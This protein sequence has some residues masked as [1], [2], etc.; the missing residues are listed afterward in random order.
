MNSS[1][2][3]G[4]SVE[5][6]MEGVDTVISAVILGVETIGLW[7]H[8]GNVLEKIDAS[9]SGIR[10]QALKDP[11]VFLPFARI[12]WLISEAREPIYQKAR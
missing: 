3:L 7:I 11:A 5:I 12:S 9:L 10:S 8:K 2:L 6:K 4:Q 1:Q